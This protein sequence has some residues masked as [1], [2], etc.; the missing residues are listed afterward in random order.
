MKLLPS[1]FASQSNIAALSLQPADHSSALPDGRVPRKAGAKRMD[2][3]D[4]LLGV[5]PGCPWKDE[6]DGST[7]QQHCVVQD[8]GMMK[9]VVSPQ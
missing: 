2:K 3:N 9:Q 6:D 5:P 8:G 7:N 1:Y 4:K